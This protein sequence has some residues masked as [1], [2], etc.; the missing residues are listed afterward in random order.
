MVYKHKHYM[1]FFCNNHMMV[2]SN[3][4]YTYL[5]GTYCNI[6]PTKWFAEIYR[7][8]M[9]VSM[10]INNLHTRKQ[11]YRLNS[12]LH[13]IA[14]YNNNLS[15]DLSHDITLYLVDP[16]IRILDRYLINNINHNFN[17]EYIVS[18]IRMNSDILQFKKTK[19]LIIL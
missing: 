4:G 1:R 18:N 14:Y 15:H 17:V 2:Q 16:N 9:L 5:Y 19:K 7:N 6:H 11:V 10:Q 12:W 3:K 8:N 13:Y